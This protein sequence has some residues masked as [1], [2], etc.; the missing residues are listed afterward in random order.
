[1]RMPRMH[2]RTECHRVDPDPRSR[3]CE[4]AATT[5][6]TRSDR[7]VS[8]GEKFGDDSVVTAGLYRVLTTC[9]SGRSAFGNKHFGP[10]DL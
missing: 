5:S 10:L 8:S 9:L 3:A 4:S 6:A 2:V 1:M 7:E